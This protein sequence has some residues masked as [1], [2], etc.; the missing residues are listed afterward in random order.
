MAVHLLIKLYLM[1]VYSIISA[2]WTYF[3]VKNKA[4]PGWQR[5]MVAW[6]IVMCNLLM[7]LVL[8]YTAEPLFITPVA[9]CFSLA[10]FK[11]SLKA[12]A[13]FCL[14]VLQNALFML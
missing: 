5:A 14:R 13:S 11:V 9:G 8:D 7:P 6:P 4:A 10:A 1:G 2:L 12:S 3:V